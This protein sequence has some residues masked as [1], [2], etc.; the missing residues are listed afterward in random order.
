[1]ALAQRKQASSEPLYTE[2]EYLAFERAADE[3]HEYLDGVIYAMA[4]ESPEHGEISVNL[5]RI[6][7]T[8]L[9]RTPCSTYTKD[10]KVRSGPLPKLRTH[11]KGLF[12]YPDI[13]VV[14]GE[15]KYLDE[16]KDVLINPTVIIEVLSDSTEKKDRR[17]KFLRY[18]QYLPSL[19]DYVLVSQE[20]PA[21]EIF[22]RPAP[23]SPQWEYTAASGM[24]SRIV[25]PSVKCTL[26]L[27]DVYYRVTFPPT[28]EAREDKPAKAR[29]A[30]SATKKSQPAKKKSK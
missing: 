28:E 27:A 12:S 11:T 2:A 18:Q 15:R 29:K 4:G 14:C 1:M 16:Y 25:I 9:L 21:I 23:Q 8:A 3:R 19:V 20:E 6:I 5:I 10:T 17:Q 7:S 24:K 26:K 22:H 13:V 30:T